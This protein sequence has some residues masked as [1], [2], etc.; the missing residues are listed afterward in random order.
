M[1]KCK[2]EDEQDC[3]CLD[4]DRECLAD[5]FY[6]SDMCLY[7]YSNKLYDRMKEVLN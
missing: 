4:I 6:K 7:E 5:E 1:A 3:E 2:F